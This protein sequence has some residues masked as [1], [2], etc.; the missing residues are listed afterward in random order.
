MTIFFRSIL[1]LFSN[2]TL[3]NLFIATHEAF[4]FIIRIMKLHIAC[5]QKLLKQH[6]KNKQNVL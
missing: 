1:E 2:K 5:L 6:F 3:K 4:I